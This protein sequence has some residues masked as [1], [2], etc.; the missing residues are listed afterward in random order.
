MSMDF[1]SL[2]SND[3]IRMPWN[4]WPSSKIEAAR[5]TLP[6]SVFCTPL[7][8]RTNTAQQQ[9]GQEE[10]QQAVDQTL[11]VPYAPVV[12]RSCNAALNPYCS[13]DIPNKGWTC[14]FCH[15]RQP[16]PAHY[17][18]IT[19]Q[20]VP[21]E[22]YPQY[23]AIEYSVPLRTPAAPRAYMFLVDT[24]CDE[25]ELESLKDSLRFAI[26]LL[27]ESA[28]VGLITFGEM[29]CV[30]E[31]GF[32]GDYT[33]SFVFKGDMDPK[34]G[35][36][37]LQKMLSAG[38]GAAAQQQQQQQQGQQ[39]AVGGSRFLLPAGEA[40]FAIDSALEELTVDQFQPQRGHR[41]GRCT[42]A[43][44]AISQALLQMS[45]P[46][47]PAHT[48]V[49]VTGPCTTGP[50]RIVSS[51][52]EE[53]VRSHQDLEKGIAKLFKPAEKHFTQLGD[54]MIECGHVIDVFA[55]ALEQVG[56]A[57]MCTMIER[58]GGMMV[59]TESYHHH[60]FKDSLKRQLE[61]GRVH[62]PGQMQVWT[63]KEI[64]V[65]GAIGPCASLHSKGKGAG[66]YNNV[67]DSVVGEGGTNVWKLNTLDHRSTLMFL[68]EVSPSQPDVSLEGQPLFMQFATQYTHSNGERRVR[69]VTAA[70]RWVGSSSAPEI[71]SGFDQEAAACSVARIATWKMRDEEPFE[72]IRWVDRMLIRLAAKYADY[73]KED[74]S[75]FRMNEVMTMYPQFMYHLRRSQFL[76]VF[77]NSPD[78]TAFFQ[79]ILNREAVMPMIVMIQPT[80]TSFSFNG[81]PQPV[82]LDVAS[83]TA[84][85]ILL[86][87]AYFI[88]TVH[89][90]STIAQWR[91]AKYQDLPEHSA[92]K[93]LL[94]A[95]LAEAK[96]ML[97]DRMPAPKLLECDQA[98]SQ[99][100]FLLAKLNPS[101]THS[102]TGFGQ[103]G[104][105]IFTDDVSL[106]VFL[107]H[108]SKLAVQ[109]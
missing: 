3:G 24:V 21:A 4:V 40:E 72:V 14:C 89:Y 36:Q 90:G 64:K 81:P 18:G 10:Q 77:N 101:A 22:L 16:F 83:M 104:E 60:V 25:D 98:T 94:V 6:L 73:V 27:P 57:E 15:T 87:D 68:F 96:Q 70:R 32:S 80:L 66:S 8:K 47:S 61:E 39:A 75:S 42:G 53:S 31:L 29:V 67:S 107:E 44:I 12:C 69:V 109:P 19:E 106:Q 30:H 74:P 58:T 71:V 48:M 102:S 79:M 13:V 41:K 88:V 11:T 7:F 59:L 33:R 56:L 76:Q 35:K 51:D 1:A 78:E 84:D 23:T 9:E 37:D 55:C 99:A 103:S 65:T 85:S 2:E 26:T 20:N 52:L 49:F 17:A 95:P 54:A 100:R 93:E 82:L 97:L 105:I 63:S 86:L 91:D 45:C 62:G 38:L 5:L 50:G 43:A 92:F 34:T 108:L 28:L 46:T